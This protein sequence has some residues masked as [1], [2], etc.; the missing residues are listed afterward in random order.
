M[1]VG[2]INT[3]SSIKTIKNDIFYYITIIILCFII[4]I[5]SFKNGFFGDDYSWLL[6]ARQSSEKNLGTIFFEPA[7]YEYFRPIP[8]VIFALMWKV[9]PIE[10][11]VNENNLIFYRLLVL[12]LHILITIFLYKIIKTKFSSSVA[13]ITACIFSV[14]ACHSETLY[15]INCLNELLS[16]LF[17]FI[18]LFF[19]LKSTVTSRLRMLMSILC[20]LFAVLSRESAFCFILLTFLFTYVPKSF[21][22]ES[23][24]ISFKKLT[25]IIVTV[26]VIYF[27]LRLFSF[28][29]YAEIY[30]IASY[31]AIDTNPLK[32]VY[33]FF[34]Y[35]INIIFPV[36]SIFYII[37]FENYENL[38]KAFLNPSENLKLFF[39]LLFLAVIILSVITYIIY[40]IIKSQKIQND[41]LLN[42]KY[43]T[44]VFPTLF[45]FS[46]L[47]VYLPL[48]GTAERF[49]YL[50]SAGICL[51][52]GFIFTKLFLSYEKKYNKIIVITIMILL[53]VLYTL[54]IYQRSYLWKI[55]SINTKEL[56]VKVEEKIRIKNSELN[57]SDPENY[58]ANNI[59][60]VLMLDVPTIEKG[61]YFVNQYNFNHIWSFYYPNEKIYFWFYKNPEN[62]KIDLTIYFKELKL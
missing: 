49:L 4:L 14:I 35:F 13:F 38:R 29:N 61:T 39:T 6:Q 19:L 48:D 8:K 33:K 43:F 51:L 16:A 53:I 27:F 20:F 5:P 34:H 41:E 44:L 50:P 56:L 60:N 10:T 59:K 42:S 26:A 46:A 12:I 62:I 30:S 52:F 23:N 9:F 37:G 32:Y 24:N 45:T 36:K 21:T 28:S 15:S 55:A 7:P 58:S 2:K 31:G 47:I 17:I 40:S 25:L 11:Y 3:L 54:S 57:K 1:N 22:K 18:G